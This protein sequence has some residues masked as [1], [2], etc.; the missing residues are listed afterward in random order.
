MKKWMPYLLAVYVVICLAVSLNG[1]LKKEDVIRSE[2]YGMETDDTVSLAEGDL[3]RTSFCLTEDQF[4][5]VSVKFQSEYAFQSEKIRARLYESGTDELL[6]E[7]TADLN[8]EMIRNK[9]YGSTIF[10][11]LPVDNGTGKEVSLTFSLEGE[12]IFVEPELVVSETGM[13]ASELYLNNKPVEGNLVFTARYKVGE[14]YHFR[15]LQSGIFALLAGCVLFWLV[16]TDFLAGFRLKEGNGKIDGAARQTDRGAGTKL[17]AGAAVL[18]LFLITL[19]VYVYQYSVE[20]QMNKQEESA[21]IAGDKSREALRITE[22]SG[23]VEQQ[24]VCDRNQL[25]A[26]IFFITPEQS[27]KGAS[28]NARVRDL[29][30]GE[31]CAD[32]LLD[33]A[34]IGETG[35]RTK[36]VVQLEQTAVR[37]KG[38]ILSLSLECS[39]MGDAVL[40]L[41]AGAKAA[42]A[43]L[44]V[45]GDSASGALAVSGDFRNTDFLKPMYLVLC[46]GLLLFAGLIYCAC[47]IRRGKLETVF[48]LSGLLMGTMIS[49][50]VAVYTVPD[51]PSHIDSAYQLSNELMGIPECGKPGYIFKRKDDVD[52]AVEEKQ[53][54]DFSSYERLYRQLFTKV[55]N[56]TLVECAASNNYANAGR[57]YYIPQAVGITIGRL[58]RLGTMPTL[59][60][61][62]FL[63]LLCYLLLTYLAVR[64]MPFAKVSLILIGLLPITL[65][66]A[67]SFSYDAVLN[68]VAFVF[69]SSSLAMAYD[70]GQIEISK[71]V[72]ALATGSML[73]TVKGGVYL[74]LAFLPLLMLLRRQAKTAYKAG[75]ILLFAGLPVF[76]FV[77]NN[78]ADT[79]IRLSAEQGSIVG[80]AVNKEIYTFGYLLRYPQRFIG[81]F[82]NTF[83]KQGDSYIRN[84][85]GGNLAWREVNIKWSVVIG[86]AVVVLL[87]CL[88]DGKERKISWKEKL[89]VGGIS[90][91]SFFLIELSMLLAWTPVTLNYITGVQGRYFIPFFI[92]ILIILRNRLITVKRSIERELIFTAGMLSII[93]VL[94]V[95][96][97]VCE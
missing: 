64:M 89:F 75:A 71:A 70:T 40:R 88:T 34:D 85:L 18:L 25:N 35:K 90:A 94:Q 24:F 60:L 95:V 5:G 96:Q 29:T 82:V 77:T 46:A 30:T 23:V 36:V 54:L 65:Q 2:N 22:D 37:S 14:S 31:V 26:V 58:L 7:Y 72:A 33:L 44:T 27:A 43:R 55:Q 20:P 76:A 9:D 97:F 41:T 51:E 15:A 67:A 78:L 1:F 81:M 79:F 63:S 69:V 17:F 56:E 3:I 83:Y 84:L 6:A 93:T 50:V 10:F 45:D 19:F 62:R 42:D 13:T 86:F 32:T 66:Q 53:S 74:P 12:E 80:G 92:L 28:L 52:S 48:L 11:L 57:I 61:G 49:F 38:H 87:S 21:F 73:A 91:G 16:Y 4:E 59:M 68:A 8:C 39:Q 47:F